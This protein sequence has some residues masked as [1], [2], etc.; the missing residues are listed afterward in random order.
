MSSN[1][2]KGTVKFFSDVKGYGFINE[3]VS[4]KDYFVYFK[5]CIDKI[6]KDDIVEFDIVEGTKGLQCINVKVLV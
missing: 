4:N 1:K 3:E 6:N 5:N 2:Y